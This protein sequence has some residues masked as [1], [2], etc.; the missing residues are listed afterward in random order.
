MTESVCKNVDPINYKECAIKNYNDIAETCR[1]G[2]QNGH[3]EDTPVAYKKCVEDFIVMEN[4][5]KKASESGANQV[6]TMLSS[7]IIVL[8][9][10]IFLGI[11][12]GKRSGYILGF[13]PLLLVILM[14]YNESIAFSIGISMMAGG[15]FLLPIITILYI[16]TLWNMKSNTTE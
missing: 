11:R 8:I 13:L 10:S 5:S 7:S 6:N 14:K 2:T 1:I 3:Y 15:V 16:I 9:I 12:T 4:E